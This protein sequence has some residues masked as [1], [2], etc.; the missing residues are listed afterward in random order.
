MSEGLQLVLDD[1][2]NLDHFRLARIYPD[3]GE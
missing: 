1:V 2:V 3:F